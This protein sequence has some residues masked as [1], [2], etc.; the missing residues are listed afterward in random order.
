MN[1]QTFTDQLNRDLHIPIRPKRIISVVPSQTELL[2]DLGLDSEV[3]GITKFCIHPK[4]KFTSVTKVGGTKT[5]NI[6]KIR[7]LRPDLILANKEENDQNQIEQLMQEFPVW[8]SDIHDLDDAIDMITR[9]GSVVAKESA[10]NTITEEI[11]ST[12]N[13]ATPGSPSLR[14]AYFIW[15]DPY[16]IAGSHTFI[17]SMLI[18][19]GWQNAF[20]FERYPQVSPGDVI[21]ANPDIIFLSSEPYPFKEKHIQEF[22]LLCPAAQVIVVDGELFS[23]YGSRLKYT[24]GYL[25]ELQVRVNQ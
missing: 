10:A 9:V 19:A 20:Q 5:L 17:D 11:R 21:L 8:I 1:K 22:A 7:S 13:L 15:K 18:A 2:F 6:Q 16:M 23:W 3:V 14:V 24:A 12:F 25:K 4:D